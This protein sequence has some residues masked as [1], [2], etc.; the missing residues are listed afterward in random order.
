MNNNVII[1]QTI[2][3]QLGNNKFLAM[4][5]AKN[6]VA[7]E[8]GLQFDLPRKRGF[9]KNGIN[10]IHVVLDPSDTYTVKGFK[11]N[12]RTY[13]CAELGTESNVYCDMLQGIFTDMTGLYTYL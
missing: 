2:L 3:Q 10:R 7:I 13:D 9:V 6:L 11:L 8:N 5:G 12:T 4:T 1:A